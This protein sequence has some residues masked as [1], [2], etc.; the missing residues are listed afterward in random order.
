MGRH[1]AHGLSYTACC[2]VSVVPFLLSV[3]S[4]SMG[5]DSEM[6]RKKA[7][8]LSVSCSWV[9]HVFKF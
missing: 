4:L 3:R 6:P 2:P 9:P 5:L 7:T 8:F 1:G